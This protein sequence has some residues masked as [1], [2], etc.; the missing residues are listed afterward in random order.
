MVAAV[1]VFTTGCFGDAPAGDETSTGTTT[2]GPTTTDPTTTGPTT[3][4]TIGTTDAPTTSA[5]TETTADT[6]IDPTLADSSTSTSSEGS[7]DGSSTD[8]GEVLPTFFD[9]FARAPS[10]ALGNGWVEKNAT[11]FAI[12][13]EMVVND[14][15]FFHQYYD[16][17]VTQQGEEA[18]DIELRVEFRVDAANDNNEPHLIARMQPDGLDPSAFNHCYALVPQLSLDRLCAMRFDT[19][20][21]GIGA[22]WCEPWPNA[23]FVVGDWY[24]L[25]FVVEGPGPVDLIGRLEHRV[26]EEWELVVAVEDQDL[27]DELR[28]VDPGA[29]G[30]SGGTSG[31]Y[32]LNFVFDNF[33]AYYR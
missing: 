4:T 1:A 30:F 2:S 16:Q 23:D 12:A 21:G 20:N 6:T 27:D 8:T 7:S 22:Q 5:T 18:L 29:W 24:R 28:I 26:G 13:D 14:S 11:V 25:V 3:E 31:N 19:G 33:S 15:N 32:Y 9:D 10:Q 17:V